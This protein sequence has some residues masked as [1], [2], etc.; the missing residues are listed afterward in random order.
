MTYT[1][2]P[3][4][5][6]LSAV[7][8]PIGKL[9][10]SLKELSAAA[11]GSVAVRAALERAAIPPQEV[12][13]LALGHGIQAGTG[14]NAARQVALAV[15]MP[16]MSCAFTVNI[17]CGSGMQ[18]IRAAIAS[19]RS[20][21]ASIAAAG[22]MESMSNAPFLTSTR[23]RW[24][25]RLG[26]QELD[27]AILRDSLLDAYGEHEHMGLTGERIARKFELSRTDVDVFALRSHR[28]AARRSEPRRWALR[29]RG[30]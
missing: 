4:V 7:R 16:K 20:G 22:G 10:G 30:D 11:L 13:L 27:D 6:I 1:A 12:P 19:I 14:Q 8:T 26:S 2:G 25:F 18:A 17:V 15:G 9:G 29:R 28:E 21:E 24:G 5:A 3:R 23:A